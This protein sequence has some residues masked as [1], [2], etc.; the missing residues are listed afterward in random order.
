M[1]AMTRIVTEQEAAEHLTELLDMVSR[2]EEV[3]IRREGSEA[4][5]LV[6]APADA[7]T[8]RFGA[9][10][11]QFEFSDSFFDPL[12]DEELFSSKP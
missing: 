3:V 9:Y 2:G 5:R 11:G 4:V 12:P 6:Q 1:H 8:R 10:K 7:P